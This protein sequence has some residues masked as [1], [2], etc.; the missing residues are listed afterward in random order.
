MNFSRFTRPVNDEPDYDRLAEIAAARA[1]AWHD[2]AVDREREAA[3][4]ADEEWD[5]LKELKIKN[6]K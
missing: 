2:Q 3:Q 5:C 1:D 6:A 4:W